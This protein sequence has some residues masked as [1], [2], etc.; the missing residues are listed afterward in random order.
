MLRAEERVCTLPLVIHGLDG[1]AQAGG[2]V[3]SSSTR[4][5]H[6]AIKTQ[7]GKIAMYV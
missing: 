5:E 1:V 4:G 7:E 2:E 3:F 6:A